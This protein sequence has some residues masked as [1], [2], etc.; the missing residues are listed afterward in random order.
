MAR[1]RRIAS[2]PLTPPTAGG[3]VPVSPVYWR[4]L[5]EPAVWQ[6][7]GA[8]DRR[9]LVHQ[10]SQYVGV[11]RKCGVAGLS[12]NWAPA[13]LQSP[14]GRLPWQQSKQLSSYQGTQR[15]GKTPSAPQPSRFDLYNLRQNITQ[16][17]VAQS[18]PSL[19]NFLSASP[20]PQNVGI[21]S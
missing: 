21:G 19:L 1:V 6:E 3:A 2:I 14:S 18:G 5:P 13:Q 8:Y 11:Q 12:V 20:A 9:P 4:G 17:Q 7:I 15:F 10:I 16:Q